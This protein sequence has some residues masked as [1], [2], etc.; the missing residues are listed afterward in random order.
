MNYIVVFVDTKLIVLHGVKMGSVQT[1]SFA[2]VVV[3]SM[4]IKTQL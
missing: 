4:V 2:H 3:L 1:L